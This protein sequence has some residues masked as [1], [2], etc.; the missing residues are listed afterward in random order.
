MSFG[1]FCFWSMV[2]GWAGMAVFAILEYVF[3]NVRVKVVFN[4]LKYIA[5]GFATFG[6]LI[7]AL[8]A[9]G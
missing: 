5:A 1:F 9:F 6:A 3:N 4:K 7:I 8:V 2:I